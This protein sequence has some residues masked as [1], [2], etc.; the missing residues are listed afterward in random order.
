[1]AIRHILMAIR[2]MWQVTNG[3]DNAVLSLCT[4]V[5]KL[6]TMQEIKMEL[7]MKLCKLLVNKGTGEKNRQSNHNQN[8]ES[9]KARRP[10]LFLHQHF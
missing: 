3:L 2:H 7:T 1:M 9:S 5:L 8:K 4:Q 6:K 10:D